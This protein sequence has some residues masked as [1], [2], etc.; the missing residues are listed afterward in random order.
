MTNFFTDKKKEDKELTKCLN[1]HDTKIK[2]TAFQTKI[3]WGIIVFIIICL[4]VGIKLIIS[5]KTGITIG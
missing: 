4:G 2:N 5:I 3:Q 1:E